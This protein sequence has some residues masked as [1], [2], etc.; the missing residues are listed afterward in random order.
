MEEI[1]NVEPQNETHNSQRTPTQE[2]LNLIIEKLRLEQ[3]LP[4]S[5]IT[6]PGSAIV[7]ACLWAVITVA[8]EYQI[9]YMALAVGLVVG[10]TVRYA[11]IGID[12]IFG[13]IGA[14]GA[15]F[16]CISGNF[17]SQVGFI[18]NYP[19]VNMS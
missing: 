13:I 10:F 17:L 8:T 16:G 5:I 12:K 6:S 2:E 19:D 1:P 14:A 3:K 4:F 11:G 18:V 7:M 9:G 15:L